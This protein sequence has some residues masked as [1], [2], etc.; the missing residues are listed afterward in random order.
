V[1]FFLYITQGTDKNIL[2]PKA[3]PGIDLISTIISMFSVAIAK[4][5]KEKLI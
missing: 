1:F 2:L 4:T 5:E 3:G